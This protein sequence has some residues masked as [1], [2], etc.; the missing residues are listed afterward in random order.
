MDGRRKA[1]GGGQHREHGPRPSRQRTNVPGL[2]A[3]CF[4]V[5]AEILGLLM[6]A[7]GAGMLIYGITRFERVTALLDEH[8]F[9]SARRGPF[10]LAA[11]GIII[12]VGAAVLLLV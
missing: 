10:V 4:G 11:L 3:N 5:V 1:S 7:F 9:A 12:S 6:I 2:G 8:K